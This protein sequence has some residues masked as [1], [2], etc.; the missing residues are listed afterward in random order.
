LEKLQTLEEDDQDEFLPKEFQVCIGSL[1]S[2]VVATSE[3]IGCSITCRGVMVRD[4]PANFSCWMGWPFAASR[5]ELNKNRTVQLV[6]VF[7]FY[8]YGDHPL[9]LYVPVFSKFPSLC[10]S[11]FIFTDHYM[12]QY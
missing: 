8:T 12:C 2:E 9:T 7:T 6:A 1:T 11:Y 5:I 4:S 3:P 10:M